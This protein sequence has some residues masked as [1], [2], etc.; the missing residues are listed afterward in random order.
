MLPRSEIRIVE[1]GVDEA[2]KLIMSA[3]IV[4]PEGQRI[5]EPMPLLHGRDVGQVEKNDGLG[6]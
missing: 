5:A 3:G 4:T 6:S 2:F 1:I